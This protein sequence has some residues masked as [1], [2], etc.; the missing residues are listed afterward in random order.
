[1]SSMNLNFN[2]FKLIFISLYF[3]KVLEL[4]I[5]DDLPELDK[6]TNNKPSA[7]EI[8][9]I[10]PNYDKPKVGRKIFLRRQDSESPSIR[11][12]NVSSTVS[13]W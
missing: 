1:M 13:I 5:R 6:R 2:S 4:T 8:A 7:P 3:I 12:I 11:S 10:I 9:A